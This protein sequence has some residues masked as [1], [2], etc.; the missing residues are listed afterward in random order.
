MRRPS[1]SLL[2]VL[3]GAVC[4]TLTQAGCEDISRLFGKQKEPAAVPVIEAQ[5]GWHYYVGGPILRQDEHEGAV[6]VG[7]KGEVRTPSS[8]GLLIGV[9]QNPDNTFEFA[10]WVNGAKINYSKGFIAKD[11]S[12]RFTERETMNQAGKIVARQSFTY[13]E[14]KRAIKSV[15]QDIDPDT[16]EVI[17]TLESD[18]TKHVKPPAEED[19]FFKDLD[20]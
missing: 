2:A 1:I 20:E 10:T 11:G 8:R 9:K 14:N 7:F 3:I 16:G 5:P 6:F 13:D 12:Y 19:E 4:L 17:R 15:T 18:L